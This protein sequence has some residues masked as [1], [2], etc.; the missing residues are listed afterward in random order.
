MILLL[1]MTYL[2]NSLMLVLI[3]TVSHKKSLTIPIKG[4]IMTIPIKGVIMTIPI[5]GVIRSRKSK[6]KQYNAQK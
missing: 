2:H 1:N 3:S 6:N 5:K 4:V